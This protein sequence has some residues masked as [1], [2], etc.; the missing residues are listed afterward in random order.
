MP[1]GGKVVSWASSDSPVASLP[2]KMGRNWALFEV[3]TD[4]LSNEYV[5]EGNELSSVATASNPTVAGKEPAANIRQISRRVIGISTSRRK[6][7][8]PAASYQTICGALAVDV[9]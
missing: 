4:N 6:G 9:E 7:R 1:P 5:A 2:F 3:F 8:N